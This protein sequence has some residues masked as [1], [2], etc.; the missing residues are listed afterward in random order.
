MEGFLSILAIVVIG[1]IIFCIYFIFKQI[2]FVLVA[3]NLYKKMVKRQNAMIKI[4]LD[5]RDQTK[6]FNY[7]KAIAQFEEESDIDS[8]STDSIM[9]NDEE[10]DFDANHNAALFG[11]PLYTTNEESLEFCYHCGAELKKKV[12]TC[13]KCGKKL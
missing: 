1:F 2:Q 13:P 9:K 5:I 10:E 7:K 6:I 8:L 11:P 12:E 4:L 3:V